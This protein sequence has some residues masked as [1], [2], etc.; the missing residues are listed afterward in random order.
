MQFLEYLEAD[1]ETNEEKEAETLDQNSDLEAEAITNSEV[2]IGDDG[3]VALTEQEL[4]VLDQLLEAGDRGAFHYTYSQFADNDDARLTAKIST[5]T[6][7]TGGTAFASNAYLQD[8][9]GDA[10]NPSYPGI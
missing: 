8:K 4:D 2:S 6:D 7:L 5:F 9:Y 10:E 1:L 3:N